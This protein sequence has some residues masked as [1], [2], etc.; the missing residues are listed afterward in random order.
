MLE[1][2]LFVEFN[3]FFEKTELAPEHVDR[4]VV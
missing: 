1:I 4:V 3:I 2:L